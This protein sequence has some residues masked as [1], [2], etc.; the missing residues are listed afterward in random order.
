MI[1]LSKGGSLLSA[2]RRIRP[3]SR[4]GMSTLPP[5]LFQVEKAVEE[6]LTNGKP[7]VALESTIIAHGMPFPQNLELANELESILRA[8]GVT[9]A[10]IAIKNGVCRIGLSLEELKDLALSGEEKRAKKCSTR[11]LPVILAKQAIIDGQG[12]KWGATT[13]ASTMK[14]ASLAGISTFVT[15]GI[16]GVHRN[17]ENSMDISADLTELAKTP[18]VVVS[19]GVKSILDIEVGIARVF[20]FPSSIAL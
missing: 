6:A 8:K 4:R 10:T 12:N 2:S 14:L 1:I 20:S 16:G 19:A 3:L 17:G 7:V 11:D 13:V 15:G 5:K 9:P 18:V